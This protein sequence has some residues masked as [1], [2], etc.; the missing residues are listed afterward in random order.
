MS[1]PWRDILSRMKE[2]PPNSLYLTDVVFPKSLQP[3]DH[4]DILQHFHWYLYKVIFEQILSL[5]ILCT[6]ALPMCMHVCA[7]EHALLPEENKKK[8]VSIPEAGVMDD[9]KES[10]GRE[11]SNPE[12]PKE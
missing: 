6:H 8:S 4:K 1:L 5:F 10:C 11:E 3:Q 2:T 12:P 9:C 7:H